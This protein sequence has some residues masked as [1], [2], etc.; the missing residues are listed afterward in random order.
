MARASLLP[1]P[2]SLCGA[3]FARWGYNSHLGCTLSQGWVTLS[4][5]CFD[6]KKINILF[7]IVPFMSIESS[8]QWEAKQMKALGD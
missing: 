5:Q 1:Q 3:G 4:P 8:V 6:F 2:W 7:L